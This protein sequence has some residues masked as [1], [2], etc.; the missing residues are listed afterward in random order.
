MRTVSWESIEALISPVTPLPFESCDDFVSG[1][2]AGRPGLPENTRIHATAIA[3]AP[4]T[5]SGRQRPFQ[6]GDGHHREATTEISSDCFASP[7][8]SCF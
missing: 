6:R 5:T 8:R 7:S 2:L 4:C 1:C 3:A